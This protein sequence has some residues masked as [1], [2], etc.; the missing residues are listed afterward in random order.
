MQKNAVQVLE[1][2]LLLSATQLALWLYSEAPATGSGDLRRATVAMHREITG[3]L[4]GDLVSVLEKSVGGKAGTA[5]GGAGAVSSDLVS[6]L[7]RFVQGRLM[8]DES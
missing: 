5:K 2:V 1:G 7:K 8:R 6:A 3:E 4:A